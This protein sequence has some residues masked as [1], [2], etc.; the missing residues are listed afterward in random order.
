MK[1]PPTDC[2]KHASE[3]ASRIL[4]L[5][6]ALFATN[7]NPAPLVGTIAFRNRVFTFVGVKI[8]RKIFRNIE[9]SEYRAFGTLGR[10]QTELYIELYTNTHTHTHT[11]TLRH[12]AQLTADSLL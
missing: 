1:I 11:H 9:I 12:I 10:P 6:H 8:F 3:L 2:S 4:H 7:M 5:A